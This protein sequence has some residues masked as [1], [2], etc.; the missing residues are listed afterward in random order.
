MNTEYAKRLTNIFSLSETFVRKNSKE[1]GLNSFHWEAM[2]EK[3]QITAENLVNFRVKGGLSLGLDDAHKFSADAWERLSKLIPEDF[4]IQGLPSVDI[5]NAGL[6]AYQSKYL[7][8]NKLHHIY[9]LYLIKELISLR[10]E[11]STI[12]CEIGG[13]FGSLTQLLLGSHRKAI[14][15]DL[16]LSNTL[17]SYYLKCMFPNKKF[18]LFDDYL[19]HKRPIQ[20]RDFLDYDIFILPPGCE[21]ADEIKIGLFVN[22]RSFMEMTSRSIENHFRFIERHSKQGGYFLNINRYQKITSGEVINFHQ[23]PYDSRWK[24]LMSTQLESQPHIHLLLSQRTS[25]YEVGDIQQALRFCA[26][27]GSRYRMRLVKLSLSLFKIK[28]AKLKK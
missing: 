6:V 1:L 15:I 8:F 25:E 9:W 11:P 16:P 17:A 18:F 27:I 22:A 2:N 7:D 10:D 19:A 14:L 23:F 28:L 20:L 13:G 4:I 24:S 5:G 3:K 12:V 21:Y 26:T